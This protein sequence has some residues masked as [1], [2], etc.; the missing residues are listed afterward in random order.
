MLAAEY[1]GADHLLAAVRAEHQ[2]FYRR[3]FSH[4]L[5][6]EPRP[7]PQLAKPIS[8]MTVHFPS[9]AGGLYRRYPFFRSSIFEQRRM[10]E[11]HQRSGGLSGNK[12]ADSEGKSES[13]GMR[14][15]FEVDAAFVT[16]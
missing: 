5:L 11:R 2:A 7:Y 6:C 16:G 9:A 13:R 1:F 3:A 8:L 14:P 4:Q 15:F 10:F 12:S